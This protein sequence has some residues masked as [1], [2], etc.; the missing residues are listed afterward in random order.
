MRPTRLKAT[1]NTTASKPS[2]PVLVIEDHDDTREMVQQ[3]LEWSGFPTV[4][5]PNGFVGLTAL[6]EHRPCLILLDLT[7]PVMDG[8]TFR[9]EQQQLK[10]ASLAGVPV[11][12][13]S[14]MPDCDIYANELGCADVIPKPVNFEQMLRVVR[15]HCG[16]RGQK[17]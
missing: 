14:A 8:W 2:A 15:Q 4:V 5:A 6:R 12:L 16:D 10:D 1:L 7:M 11:L 13:L 3:F 9:A 17:P